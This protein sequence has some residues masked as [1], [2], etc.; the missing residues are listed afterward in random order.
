M[1]ESRLFGIVYYLLEK[2]KATAPELAEKFEVSVRTIYR[3]ID[4]ISGAGIPIYA[5]QGKGGGIFLLDDFVL[6]R[7]FLS[8]REKE[9]MMMALQGMTAVEGAGF[10]GLLT[11]LGGLF[12]S[13]TA[14]WIEVDFSGWVK[15]APGQ[16]VFNAIK[17]AV[18]DRRVIAFLYF[19]GSGEM[20]RRRVEPLKLV[21]KDKDWYMYGYCLTREDYRFFKLTRI[22]DLEISADTYFRELSDAVPIQKQIV[23]EAVIR[24]KL[25]FDKAAAFRVYDEFSGQV[26]RDESGSLYVETDL[27]AHDGLYSYLLSFSDSVEV[28]GPQEVRDEM[29]RKVWNL[30]KKYKT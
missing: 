29:K 2:G 13:R 30:Q 7:L 3:D 1:Q 20:T 10:E 17:E 21:F 26:T 16:D 6:D 9:Q 5:A 22:K 23:S 27:P 24:V 8:S 19:G 12:R 14:S 18:F 28:L 25:K 15:N 4:A 11:K